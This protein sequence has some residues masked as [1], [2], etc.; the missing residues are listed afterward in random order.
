MESKKNSKMVTPSST[1]SSKSTAPFADWRGH[2]YLALAAC[3]F[4]AAVFLAACYYKILRPGEF[5]LSV[6]TYGI[7]PTVLINPFSLV[8]PWV[9]LFAAFM[10]IVGFRTQAA[11]LLM[12]AMMALF[13]IALVIALAKGLDMSCGCFA[14]SEAGESINMLTLARDLAWLAISAYILVY[15]RR[16]LG[17]DRILEKRIG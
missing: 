1:Q 16:P 17:L 2:P 4:I 8:L 7:L 15:D 3:L 10:L 14:S 6:A 11:A 12:T 9:E 5:A 13:T